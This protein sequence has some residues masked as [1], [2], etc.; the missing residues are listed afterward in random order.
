M[1]NKKVLALVLFVVVVVGLA[2]VFAYGGNR[3]TPNN[4]SSKKQTTSSQTPTNQFD[5]TQHSTTQP[6]SLW[7]VVNKQH[8][9]QPRQFTP[10]DLVFPALPLRVPGNESMQLRK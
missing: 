5:K 7:A 9:L 8:A 1:I 10:T 2:L 3:K 6:T 4:T